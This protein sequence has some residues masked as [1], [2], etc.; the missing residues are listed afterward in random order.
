MN[1]NLADLT[2]HPWFFC[3]IGGSGMLP[4]AMILHGQGAQIAGSD[5][6]RDQGR[7]PEKFA[8]LEQQGIA[9]FPQDGSGITSATQTLIASAAVEDTVPEMVR[10]RELGSPRMSRADLLSTLFNRAACSIAIGG[11]SGKSTVTGMLGW[12]L[13]SVGR[14]PTI[15]NGAV[16]KNFVSADTP[17]ASARV[18]KG[19]VFVSEVDESDGSIALYRPTVA[20]LLNVSLDHKSMEELRE[21]FGNFLAA[22]GTSAIN[23]DD[24]ES[25]A[26][27]GHAQNAVTYGIDH[28]DATIGV[29]AGSIADT[30]T[31][32]S[33]RL[34][35]RRDGSRHALTLQVPGRHN[36]SNAL[37]AI[38]GAH[39]AGIPVADAVAAIAGFSGLA[40]RFDIVGTSASGITVIDDFGHNP[41]KCRATLRTLKSHPGRVIAFFQPHGYGPLRQMGHELAQTFAEELGSDDI[42][43][44]CDPVYF[45]GT[46][47]RSEGS[48]RI[49][50][51]IAEFG[52]KA[53]YVP[54]REACGAMITAIAKP[55]DRIVIMGARDDTLS[56]FAREILAHLA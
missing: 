22:A 41:E 34:I 48:E 9:L 3:G 38:A 19:A 39:A 28:P 35:D 53:E 26:L 55:G 27:A 29:E 12:I 33:A 31:G 46:V 40:R 44:L 56:T 50:R 13:Y 4:L 37:A 36:L 25:R 16:M 24:P 6:S 1:D 18:G 54:D 43:I 8:W 32:I 21:L 10:A 5:R 15:M 47:D 2:S 23:W 45:G 42:T 51:L 30:P 11:T 17:F 14:D 7:T 52:G 49:T 20:V